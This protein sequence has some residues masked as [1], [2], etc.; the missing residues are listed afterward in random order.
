[1]KTE[2]FARLLATGLEP[3]DRRAPF[4]RAAWAT[5]AGAALSALAMAAWL[6]IRPSLGEDIGEPMFWVKFALAASVAAGA[7]RL[8]LRLARP[9]TRTRSTAWIVAA[10]LA[11]IWLLAGLA[12]LAAEPAGRAALVLGDTWRSCPP[13]IAA[14]SVPL[15]FAALWAARQFAPT[16]FA[17]TGAAAGLFAGAAAAFVY[18]FHC[19]E[20]AAPFL[21]VWYVVGMAI[22]AALGALA[23]PRV[24]RW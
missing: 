4:R 21:A 7:A 10:P 18:A 24:L 6:G 5:L 11:A 20:L 17:L 3:V 15:L 19:P 23:G 1:M 22:P 2:Q 13:S 14:L 8:A 12:L 9:G 16:Q